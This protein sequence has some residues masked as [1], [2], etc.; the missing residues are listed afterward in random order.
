M[1][2]EDKTKD[3]QS[4]KRPIIIPLWVVVAILITAIWYIIPTE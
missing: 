2:I 3:K 4:Y 1:F